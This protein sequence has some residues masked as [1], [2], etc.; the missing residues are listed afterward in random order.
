MP[1]AGVVANPSAAEMKAVIPDVFV[2]GQMTVNVWCQYVEDRTGITP[3]RA[4]LQAGGNSVDIN[5]PVTLSRFPNMDI[6]PYSRIKV[7]LDG[8]TDFL[9]IL[10]RRHDMGQADQVIWEA[11]DDRWKLSKIPILGC[12]V[13][14]PVDATVKFLTRYVH[15]VNPN[16]DHNCIIAMVGGQLMPVFSWAAE[17]A[18]QAAVVQV[19]S[20]QIQADGNLR[21]WTPRLH[22]M[23]LCGLVN[24]AKGAVD[25]TNIQ[26]WRSISQSA[27][28]KWDPSSLNFASG[29]DMDHVMPDST[30]R[31][32]KILGAICETLKHSNTYGLRMQYEGDVS[33]VSFYVKDSTAPQKR[34]LPLQ[35][36]GPANDANTIYD[37]DMDEDSGE[38]AEAVVALGSVP[39]VETSV[40]LSN[41][42]PD[43]IGGTD[44]LRPGWTGAED[45]A[46]RRCINGG[47]ANVTPPP[48]F[49]TYPSIIN[50]YNGSWLVADGNG[51]RPKISA[52]TADAVSLCR[53][54]FP[55]WMRAFRLNSQALYAASQALQGSDHRF[56]DTTQFPYL[57]MPRPILETQLTYLLDTVFKSKQ[58]WPIRI[59][60][61]NLAAGSSDFTLK[62]KWHDVTAQAGVEV[63]SD[64]LIYLSG[65]TD[66]NSAADL[67]Y[68]GQM[69]C[70]FALPPATPDKPGCQLRG[71]RINLAIPTDGRVMG[72][73]E[74]PG[75]VSADLA[76]EL[77]GPI[78]D[79]ID[80]PSAWRFEDRVKSR[81]VASPE[82][83][84]QDGSVEYYTDPGLTGALLD[85]SGE[86]LKHAQQKLAITKR[87]RQLTSWKLIGIRPDWHAGDYVDRVTC[88][89]AAGDHD[90]TLEAALDVVTRDY[91]NQVT[92]CGNTAE[93]SAA[94]SSGSSGLSTARG[95]VATQRG[96]SNTPTSPPATPSYKSYVPENYHPESPPPAAAPS[97]APQRTSTAV[98][99]APAV[100]PTS[101]SD[102]SGHE[103]GSAGVPPAGQHE[104]GSAG[105]PPAGQHEIGSAGV[106]PAQIERARPAAENPTIGALQ[107]ITAKTEGAGG[108]RVP[109]TGQAA[110]PQAGGT[111]ALPG[112]YEPRAGPGEGAYP[113]R[114]GKDFSKGPGTT[115]LT[116][117]RGIEMT[118]AGV[119]ASKYAPQE[120]PLGKGITD[121]NPKPPETLD[122]RYERMT[123]EEMGNPLA[124]TPEQEAEA[125]F[126][127]MHQQSSTPARPQRELRGPAEE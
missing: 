21:A 80:S 52:R 32:Q 119:D 58:R 76:K 50:D 57:N 12:L 92:V 104:I 30:F 83:I 14:D 78:E 10:K 20:A 39:H 27:Y 9:G 47:D 124:P 67:I 5:G 15:R 111:P 51:G 101:G 25:G 71:I 108:T 87:R 2:N 69:I 54:H 28:L 13:Y 93:H 85:E 63:K 1:A 23:Y 62:A 116:G 102:A 36:G 40:L 115:P 22:L 16:G 99:A 43:A 31:G 53:Q 18:D 117:P 42:D 37:F 74:A 126:Q 49:A 11:W 24:L 60:I 46:A 94:S 17:A 107:G 89:G 100:G 127:R 3:G 41:P 120:R 75:D 77:Q 86:A 82:A 56:Q 114:E 122:Q 72:Y 91:A 6:K 45:A 109:G 125:H 64:N 55:R 19:Q 38:T 81:P 4:M 105:V 121:L 79:V 123:Q 61:S 110:L 65:L 73:A 118:G 96:P 90:Y 48:E 68:T 103:I 29:G 106:P 88:K 98:T 70:P 66:D 84:R 34:Q 113:L 35:R 8:Y 112:K 95:G 97:T 44:T 26:A 59:E 7:V 33:S